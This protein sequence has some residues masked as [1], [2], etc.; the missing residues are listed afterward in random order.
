MHESGGSFLRVILEGNF[1]SNFFGSYFGVILGVHYWGH[2]GG[3]GVVLPT[4]CLEM[5]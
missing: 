4:S 5:L 2:F 1:F 3:L